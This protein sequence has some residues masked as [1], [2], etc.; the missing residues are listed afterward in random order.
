MKSPPLPPSRQAF[1]EWYHVTT[2]GQTLRT[3]EASYLQATLKLTYNQ[4]TLQVGYLGSEGL[5]IDDNFPGDFH[6]MDR[7]HIGTDAP[8]SF[9]RADTAFLPVATESIDTIILPHVME[10]AGEA[11]FQ[12]L[13][14][15]ERVLKPEGRLLIL[16]LNPWSLQGLLRY[17]L[18]K[19]TFWQGDFVSSHR[20]MARLKLLKIDTEFDAAFGASSARIFDRPDTLWTRTCAALSFAYAVKGVKRRYSLIPMEP[21]WINLPSLATGQLYT[22]TSRPISVVNRGE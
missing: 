2:L 12:V 15:V 19:S 17:L 6:L 7:E 11:R 22:K 20:L 3:I 8:W 21:A 5:Y 16:S 10:F 1:L 13:G 14:E 9:A 4:K 18:R